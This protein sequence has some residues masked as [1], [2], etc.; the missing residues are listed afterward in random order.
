[1]DITE[2]KKNQSAVKAQLR[3]DVVAV[4]SRADSLSKKELFSAV[5]DLSPLNDIERQDTDVDSASVLY[6][7]LIGAV[8]SD[9]I[10]MGEIILLTEITLFISA[11]MRSRN[12]SKIFLR[13]TFLTR[14][15][16]FS[17]NAKLP[18][19]L[20]KPIQARMITA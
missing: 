5:Y 8:L 7:S 18:L 20:T 19:A 11:D 15:G 2:L 16:K 6:R 9:A 13:K 4:L 3:R 12:M 17:K 1:M 14:K 10:E